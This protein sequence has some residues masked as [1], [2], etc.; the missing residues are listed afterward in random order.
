MGI[1]L[2]TIGNRIK[3]LREKENLTQT[4]LAA[5]FQL[6]RSAINSWEMGLTLPSTQNII[7][8]SRLFHISTDYLLGIDENA[9]ISISG[10]TDKQVSVVYDMIQCLKE[11][12]TK[13]NQ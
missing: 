12:N 9:A 7:E 11:S 2:Y 5:K 4:Q 1:E 3:Q 10:L 8:L 6:S 13:T